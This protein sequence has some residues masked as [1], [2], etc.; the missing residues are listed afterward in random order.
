M[1]VYCAKGHH[2]VTDCKECDKA[3]CTV[4]GK[5]WLKAWSPSIDQ[6]LSYPYSFDYSEFEFQSC[7]EHKAIQ[8]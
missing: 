8:K 2:K 1:K 5:V 7:A 6:W 3:V 4:C